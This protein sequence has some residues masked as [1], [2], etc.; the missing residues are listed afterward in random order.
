MLQ[1]SLSTSSLVRQVAASVQAQQSISVRRPTISRASS[2]FASPRGLLGSASRDHMDFS[3]LDCF[4]QK[5]SAGVGIPLEG[6]KRHVRFDDK[7]GQSIVVDCN[8]DKDDDEDSKD[9]GSQNHY[10]DADSSDVSFTLDETVKA[11]FRSLFP[12]TPFTGRSESTSFPHVEYSIR[13]LQESPS[14]QDFAADFS[15][16]RTH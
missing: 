10:T 15:Q 3:G 13:Q 5:P 16:G 11:P 6:P 2:E 14:F 4:S 7:V 12:Q 8:D 9:G 1:R